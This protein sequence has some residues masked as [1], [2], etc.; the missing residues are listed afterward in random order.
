[1][2]VQLTLISTVDAQPP[3]PQPHEI[4]ATNYKSEFSLFY[5]RDVATIPNWPV[6]PY[7]DTL[8]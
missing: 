6:Q 4:H 2:N 7:R 8:K 3:L 1:M 5:T